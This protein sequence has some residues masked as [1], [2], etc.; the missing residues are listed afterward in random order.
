MRVHFSG[1]ASSGDRREKMSRLSLTASSLLLAIGMATSAFAQTASTTMPPEGWSGPISDAFFSDAKAGT[2]KSE[3]DVKANWA[4]L[5]PEQQTMVKN[6][7]EKSAGAA[8]STTAGSTP[9]TTGMA[10][11]CAMVMKM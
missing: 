6:D 9:P 3:A 4:K 8:G 7:C 5:T 11:V 1:T 10:G 2:L